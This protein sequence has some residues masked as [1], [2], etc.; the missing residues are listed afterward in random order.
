MA[1]LPELMMYDQ[2]LPNVNSVRDLGINVANYCHH[3]TMY[4]A[5]LLRPTNVLHLS[6]DV[7]FLVI[8]I[9]LFVLSKFML[10]R[11]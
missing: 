9:Y 10:G 11:Y 4:V 7:L 3:L 8:L 1:L 5:L 2:V 6:I